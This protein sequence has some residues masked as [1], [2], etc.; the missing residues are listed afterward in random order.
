MNK[1]FYFNFFVIVLAAWN[2]IN[3]QLFSNFQPHLLFGTVGLVFILFNWTRHAVFSTI[4]SSSDRNKKIRFANLSKKV[5]PFHRWIGT[6]ALI[7]IG[8]HAAFV[9]NTYGFQWQNMKL[10]SGILTALVL[11]GVVITG[12]MRRIR[13]SGRKRMAHLRLGIVMFFLVLMH[14]IL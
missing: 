13:P 2:L 11:S 9:I 8:I 4:R 1:W 6:S 5:L 14:L 12:W 7:F 3:K 10:A